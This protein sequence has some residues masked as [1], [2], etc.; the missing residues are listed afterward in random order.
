M[1]NIIFNV[2]Y[3]IIGL[4]LLFLFVMVGLIIYKRRHIIHFRIIN[5]ETKEPV[6]HL[7][8]YGISY[9]QGSHLGQTVSGEFVRVPGGNPRE[10]MKVIGKTDETGAFKATYWMT[11]YGLFA[12]P[13]ENEYQL[14]N[15]LVVTDL[16]LTGKQDTIK[17]IVV[18]KNGKM[19]IKNPTRAPKMKFKKLI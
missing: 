10:S 2:Y 11:S 17:T 8:I 4:M 14:P 6:S 16:L 12:F 9:S 5:E 3:V 1:E 13:I 18:K 19:V 15:Q 7:N